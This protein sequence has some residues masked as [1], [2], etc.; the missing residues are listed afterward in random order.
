MTRV[1]IEG[2]EESTPEGRHDES[3]T[4]EEKMSREF[5]N[6]TVRS[7]RSEHQGLVTKQSTATEKK[8]KKVIELM[9]FSITFYRKKLFGVDT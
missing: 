2:G 7:T 1:A 9:I 5:L 8:K 3:P 4:R 6:S